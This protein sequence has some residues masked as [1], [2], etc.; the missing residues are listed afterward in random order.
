MFLCLVSPSHSLLGPIPQP[1]RTHSFSED[2]VRLSSLYAFHSV[3]EKKKIKK[4]RQQLLCSQRTFGSLSKKKK[5]KKYVS[6]CALYEHCTDRKN[7]AEKKDTVLCIPTIG[8]HSAERDSAVE[9]PFITQVCCRPGLV[10]P[11][12]PYL[13][14]I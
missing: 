5:K 1:Q 13:Y 7:E 9:I 10:G 11:A 4:N 6:I 3:H 8:A 14:D 2:T 12:H